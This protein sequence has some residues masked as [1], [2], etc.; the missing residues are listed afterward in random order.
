MAIT[1]SL[2]S[3]LTNGT[4]PEKTTTPIS[5]PGQAVSP[6][7][8]PSEEPSNSD[9]YISRDHSS[10]LVKLDLPGAPFRSGQMSSVLLNFTFTSD[11][12][13]LVLNGRIFALTV[14]NPSVPA[15]LE[16]L[17]IPS[18]VYLAPFAEDLH[19]RDSVL[20]STLKANLLLDYDFR[21][22]NRDDPNI[23]YYNYHPVLHVNI[24]GCL[25]LED[26][27]SPYVLLDAPSQR[28]VVISMRDQSVT[29]SGDPRRN[30]TIVS[31]QLLPRRADY[32]ATEPSDKS[33]SPFS[34]RCADIE[35]PPWYEV[36]WQ[37][38]F[39]ELGRIGSLRWRFLRF[40][41]CVNHF[42][43]L[44]PY[45]VWILV[46]VGIVWRLF[47]L[48]QAEVDTEPDPEKPLL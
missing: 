10:A 2:L 5:R 7:P 30:F 40:G 15:R 29:N 34:W 12:H 33:C 8:K 28:T 32:R 14:P 1:C 38:H 16:V 18:S 20:G 3:R 13:H 48:R 22:Q 31:V 43:S 37:A 4:I 21:F 27:N 6:P 25:A 35:D 11:G 17:Q 46:A 36:V 42:V 24:I 23:R 47:G 26:D 19:Y 44:V 41:S 9:F 39:D 45:P